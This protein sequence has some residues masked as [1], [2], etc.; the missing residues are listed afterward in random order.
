MNAENGQLVQ[1]NYKTE[2]D[3]GVGSIRLTGTK[4]LIF[5]AWETPE[6]G[7]YIPTN[8]QHCLSDS[9]RNPAYD[10]G[11]FVQVNS[12]DTTTTSSRCTRFSYLKNRALDSSNPPARS[13]A[14]SIVAPLFE[15]VLALVSL[16]FLF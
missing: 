8:F 7:V 5:S 15:L 13:A 9:E 2:T 4:T 3:V 10:N 6:E 14:P 11:H 12:Y 1:F 16:F